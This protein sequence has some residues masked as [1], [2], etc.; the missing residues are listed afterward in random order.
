[1]H[2]YIYIYIYIHIRDLYMCNP[3]VRF[4]CRHF[5][6][7][8]SVQPI[9][10]FYSTNLGSEA[11][12]FGNKTNIIFADQKWV[13]FCNPNGVVFVPEEN[14]FTGPCPHTYF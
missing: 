10:Q 5:R 3:C 1:M 11:I 4:R 12:H 13:L 2:I 6:V 8:C 14:I 7:S 9:A